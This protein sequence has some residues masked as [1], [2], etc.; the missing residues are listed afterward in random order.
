MCARVHIIRL[1]H[2]CPLTMPPARIIR[3]HINSREQRCVLA[4]NVRPS[5][6]QYSYRSVPEMRAHQSCISLPPCSCSYPQVLSASS[7]TRLQR[8]CLSFSMMLGPSHA[9]SRGGAQTL[10]P[11]PGPPPPRQGTGPLDSWCAWSHRRSPPPR[12][13][14]GRLVGA[15]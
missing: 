8:R 4:A 5:R 1:T 6:Q 9:S 13:H 3:H 7:M 10:R 11:P 2:A 15:V 12:E 14:P